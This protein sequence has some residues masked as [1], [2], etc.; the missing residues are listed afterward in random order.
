MKTFTIPYGRGSI[1]FELPDRY[2]VDW[3]AP[4]EISP[5]PNPI[6][7]VYN[8]LACPAGRCSLEDFRGSQSAAIAINDKTR[9]VPHEF[10]LPPLLDHLDQMGISPENTL[11][12]VAT[13]THVPMKKSELGTILPQ[14]ILD[15]YPAISHD[16]DN[17]DQLTHLG[18]TQSGTPVA[19]NRLFL[20]AD[21][22]IVV[23][24]IEPHHFMGFSGG[25][26]TAAIGL[27]A[28]ETINHN[29][30]MLTHPNA[31][32]AVFDQNPMRQD[33][34]EIGGMASVHFALNAIL[35]EE[36]QI[37]HVVAGDPRAV[38]QT[39]IPLSQSICQVASQG[40]YDLVIA[41]PGGHPKD[42]NFYQAQ[43][44]LTHAAML[45]RD[46]GCVILAAECAEGEGSQAYTSWMDGM[47]NFSDVMDRFAREGFQVGPHKA[48]QVARI[49]SRVRIIL[50]SEIPSARV[51]K[52]LLHTADSVGNAI[53][54]ELKHLEP[55]C[56]I[57]ILPRAVS[58][59]PSIA[60]IT[61]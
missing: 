37:V 21:L 42:I 33:V 48:F 13:G 1:E 19:I 31:R 57:A 14:G 29:H 23:G 28:R 58:T 25:V 2:L 54:E 46:G 11:F 32:T 39:G 61:G 56:R 53:F 51:E 22:R 12:I 30:A 3:I 44:G 27:A 24:D 34:E 16:C 18:Y 15:R 45:T 60:Q 20:N 35:N 50:V 17:P 7:E 36:K 55:G 43:K 52:L 49:G 40:E 10:L 41:S 9:P 59:I 47:R 38:M 4:T 6:Q 5:A 26:K 8:A